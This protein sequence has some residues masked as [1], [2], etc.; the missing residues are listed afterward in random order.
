MKV[1][2]VSAFEPIPSDNMR[3]MRFA[4]VTERL[5]ANGHAV[6][7][8]TGSL[9]HSD[10]KQRFDRDDRSQASS[11]HE[12]I[13]L[14]S[15][16]YSKNISF[17]RL[18]AHEHLARRLTEQFA[19]EPKPDVILVATPPVSVAAA[20]VDYGEKNGVPVVVDV[21]DPWPDAVYPYLPRPA[22]PFA[23]LALVPMNRDARRLFSRCAGITAISQQYLDW[24]RAKGGHR[25]SV[26]EA[27]FPGADLAGFDERMKS[28]GGRQTNGESGPL[29]F[30]YAGA[31]GTAYDVE[32]IISAARLLEKQGVTDMEFL[33]AGGGPRREEFERLAAGMPQV[34]FLGMLDAT[35]LARTYST[36]DA[37]IACYRQG[38]TQ[39]ITYKLF[40]YLAVGMPIISSLTGE[41]ENII[42]RERVGMHYEP[43]NPEALAKC[44]RQL[45]DDREAMR[46]MGARGRAFTELH[47]DNAKN[48]EKMVE[49]LS[50][51]VADR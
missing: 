43:E 33:I 51:V 25:C 12:V 38:A 47:G 30:V 5:L 40:D 22:R 44:L 10:R 17:R 39:S 28:V 36:S 8:W 19:K 42:T 29:R 14:K 32:T 24:A 3:P 7:T 46:A 31:L 6:V 37:G 18:I 15:W 16:S 13:T 20:V 2:L 1:W 50:S 35:E 23:K 41:M 26:G 48:Y 34:R 4:G 27:I 11:D 9:R 45:A 21:I 49:V